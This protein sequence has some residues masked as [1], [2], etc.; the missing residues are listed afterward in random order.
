ML[1]RGIAP[2][3]WPSCI[4]PCLSIR[5]DRFFPLFRRTL[6][7]RKIY[8]PRRWVRDHLHPGLY[9]TLSVLALWYIFS[10]WSFGGGSYTDYL[11]TVANG[12]ILIAVAVPV[13][14]WRIWRDHPHEDGAKE[15]FREWASSELRIWQD[16]VNGT[17]AA[18][19]II[20]SVAGV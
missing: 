17:D 1:F 19:G 10:A 5:L 7:T 20:L 3:G 9:L 8:R 2:H 6:M 4:F 16:R 12:L 15:P 13:A 18:V 11:L 14:L